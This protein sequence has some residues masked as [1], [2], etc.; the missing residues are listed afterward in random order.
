MAKKRAVWLLPDCAL[1]VKQSANF[2]RLAAQ[3]QLLEDGVDL[4]D[5]ALAGAAD[6][7]RRDGDDRTSHNS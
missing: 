2:L 6:L 4:L 7:R 3:N 5:A 1:L